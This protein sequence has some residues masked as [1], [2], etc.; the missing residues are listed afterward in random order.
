MG[1][2]SST[3]A[4]S[5]IRVWKVAKAIETI[6]SSLYLDYALA[7]AAAG[8]FVVA[9]DGALEL[10]GLVTME[11]PRMHTLLAKLGLMLRDKKLYREARTYLRLLRQDAAIA[12][13]EAISERGPLKR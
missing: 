6:R 10:V 2:S 4:A 9:R 1:V 7:A 12:Q 11:D 5:L 8:N 3:S 13:L